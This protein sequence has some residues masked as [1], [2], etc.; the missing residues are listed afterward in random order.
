MKEVKKEPSPALE[1]P[2]AEINAKIVGFGDKV[3]Q[4][5]SEKADKAAIDKAVKDLL[6][7]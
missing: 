2:A 4:L 7:A 6:A 5:K 3:R 1:G